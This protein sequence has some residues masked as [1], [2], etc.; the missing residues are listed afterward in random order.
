M[1]IDPALKDQLRHY[2]EEKINAAKQV[3][4][5]ESAYVLDDAEKETL[6]ASLPW[7]KQAQIRYRVKPD[8][9]A[10][11]VVRFGSRVID[12]SVKGRLQ[13][14]NRLLYETD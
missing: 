7:L 8:L 3:V 6:L 13:S 1:K 11:V 12:L 2:L 14:Y 10:G 5:V 9:I 4:T